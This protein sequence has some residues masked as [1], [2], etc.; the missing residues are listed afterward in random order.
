MAIG[1]ISGSVLKSNLTRNGTDLAFET[2]LLYLDVTNSRVGIGTS[3]PSTTLHINGTTTTTGLTATSVTTNDIVSN[4]SNADITLDPTG[5]GDIN[6]TAGADVNIPADIGLTF[7]NDGEKIEGDGTDLK[8]NSSGEVHITSSRVSIGT[9]NPAKQFQ[10]NASSSDMPFLRLETTDGGNKR[11]DL[12]VE[13][14]IGYIGANQ[15][16]QRLAFETTG[17]ERMRIDASGNVGIG[18]TS[19]STALEVNGTIQFGSLSDGTITATAFV[20][21][22]DM[23]SNSATLIPT[24]Q[25]VKAYVDT[26]FTGGT[27]TFTGASTDYLTISKSSND[28]VLHSQISDGDIIF[29]GNDGGSTITAL[30]LNMSEAG[31]ATFNNDV[32]V[33]NDL[34]VGD[35][36]WFEG[37]NKS[38]YF[39]ADSDIRLTHDHNKGLILKNR[40]GT[41]DTPIILTLQTGETAITVG[42]KIGVIDFQA[43]N[44]AGGTDAITVA[45]GIE[46]V[47]EGTFA[48]DNNA[49]K[50]SFKTAASETAT[51]KMS[52]SSGGNLTVSGNVSVG[53]DLDVTGSFDMSDANITNIGSIA[54]DT[55]TNDGTDITLDSSG[56]I[57]L[58]AGGA[59][60]LLKDDGT[61]FGS[62]TN[63]STDLVIK[64]GTTPTT[65]MTLSQNG[66][67]EF[68]N[69]SI[70]DNTITTTAS[71]SD[72]QLNT[73]GSGLVTINGDGE[74]IYGKIGGTDFT[75]GLIIGHS[76]TGTLSSASQNT[77]VGITSLDAI[78]SGDNNTALGYS[79]LTTLTSGTHNTAVGRYA[80]GAVNNSHNTAVGTNAQKSATGSKN[81]S[82]GEDALDQVTGN[83]NIAIGYQAGDNITSGDGNVVIGKADVTA[84]GDDQLSISDAE[85]GSVVWITGAST[86]AVTI[87][88][89]YALPTGDGSSGQ[90]LQTNGSGTVSFVTLDSLA[91]GGITYDDNK[92]TGQR[93]NENIEIEA[94]G[95]G[96]IETGS[97]I[98]PKTDNT[99][100]LGSSTKKFKD[101]YSS[102]GTIYVGDQTIQS[103]ASGFVFSGTVSTSGAQVTNNDDTSAQILS[104]KGIGTA[105]TTLESYAT[106]AF[107]SALYYIVARDE[108]NDQVSSQKVITTHNNTTGFATTTHVTK[109]G[110]EDEMTFDGSVSGGSMR[111]RGTGS[112]ISNSI[113]AYKLALGDNSSAGTSGNTAIIINADVDSTTEN[114]DTWVHATY[115]G[116]KYFISVNDEADDELEVIECMVVHNGTSAFITSYNNTRTGSTSLLTLTADISGGS[117][118]LR[119]AGSRAN[120]NVKMHRIL[121]SDSETTYTGDQMAI[122]KATTISSSSTAIDTFNVST[123]H[124]AFYY[125]VSTIANG[126]S[127]MV[128]IAVATD[129]TDAY[130]TSGPTISSEGTDQLTFTATISGDIVTVNAASSSGS[131]TTVNAYRINL[132]RDAETDVTNTVLVT[133]TQTISGAKTLSSALAMTVVG[134]DPSGVANNAHIYAKD[135]TS[136]AEVYVRDEAGNV[137]KLS[138]HNKQGEWEYFSRN[139]ITGK[140]VRVNME[141]MIKDIEKLTGK[142]YIKE[143]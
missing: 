137:T 90:Y 44:E 124:G 101:I 88:G 2:N 122:V 65:V 82:L 74:A 36:L 113:S 78:T 49:T 21:E 102:S 139:T 30:W 73:A 64:A 105:E 119:G 61:T 104:K 99:Y 52:L 83:S 13:S 93:S 34:M 72:L 12:R 107:D 95:S 70:A 114:L 28:A 121:L 111:L 57:I 20:D 92:I 112:T 23:S 134:S 85:D 42:E 75:G 62:L 94:N 53:G 106:S 50:L 87:S 11:L 14:S 18:T 118:R 27:L 60:I 6:L 25:S 128:E 133:G 63:S 17:T 76:T 58:D 115:R 100:D 66:G 129:G 16:S 38:T 37:D 138:P 5:T 29:K 24:Q 39:G 91:T 132:K 96:V 81:T 117:V 26:R 4:G 143:E 56:D 84:T 40:L 19:P 1:R 47:A 3:E 86:G 8:I 109:T 54:L 98:I 22:D 41:D 123:V 51:E 68:E 32:N 108:M 131:S 10:I 79:S 80:L 46:A 67:V 125:V 103:T 120:L 31:D 140:T 126:D 43:P 127:S 69:I 116:A 55:I 89:A 71:N 48:A 141:E 33:G 45:A 77:G 59:D 35:Y 97:S 136:S 130:V 110:S 142:K 15:S 9:T 7:G 135:D